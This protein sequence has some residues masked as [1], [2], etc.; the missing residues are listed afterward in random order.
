MEHEHIMRESTCLKSW[1]FRQK[2]MA[3]INLIKLAS[4]SGFLPC[5]YK[6]FFRKSDLKTQFKLVELFTLEL[7]FVNWH[8][9][10][11][12]AM[13]GCMFQELSLD[14]QNLMP[15]ISL[16]KLTN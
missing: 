1:G 11:I 4:N 2:F 16:N 6:L 5:M 10:I 14:S 8:N 7:N 9:V 3:P 13:M 12:L 15:I